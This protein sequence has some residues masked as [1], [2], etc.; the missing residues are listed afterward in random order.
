[1]AITK[2]GAMTDP[3][4]AGDYAILQAKL[5]AYAKQ[6]GNQGMI[7]TEW[8]NATTKP[9]IALGS[10]IVHGGT[11]FVVDTEDFAVTEPASDGTYYLKVAVSG[12]TLAVSWIASLS[13]YT[14]NAIYN[15]LYHAD[16]SQIL[17]YQLVKAGATLTK[18]K[19]TNLMQGS[20]FVTVDYYGAI[21]CT[22]INTGQGA[23]E[24]GQNLRSTDDVVFNDVTFTDVV[25]GTTVISEVGGEVFYHLSYSGT[26]YV[27]V[28]TL[29]RYE[30]IKSLRMSFQLKTISQVLTDVRLYVGD[31]YFPLS[32]PTTSYT[33]YT[34]DVDVDTILNHANDI[35]DIKVRATNTN[36]STS[37]YIAVNA[38]TIKANR[39]LNSVESFFTE[40]LVN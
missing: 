25:K 14:W 5:D 6:I 34:V 2:V 39:S 35:V 16:E 18:R 3:P 20:G 29:S 13:G 28:A 24:I 32:A 22:S 17:P 7:L 30:T 4:V 21:A 37:S 1:M 26:G 9:D 36:S 15:G 40:I 10:Y 38:F 23:F 12:D 19:I 27:E 33:D 31:E 8:I 11:L